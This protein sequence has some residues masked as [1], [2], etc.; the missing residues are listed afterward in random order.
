MNDLDVTLMAI[1]R[2][3]IEKLK[4][5]KKRMGWGFPYVSSNR[6]DFN[7]DFGFAMTEEQMAS[8]EMVG[9]LQNPPAWLQEWSRSV[10]TDRATGMREC[11]GWD[12][13]GI[14]DLDIVRPLD[15]DVAPSPPASQ[16]SGRNHHLGSLPAPD[17]RPRDRVASAGQPDGFLEGPHRMIGHLRA[18][19]AEQFDRHPRL[20]VERAGDPIAVALGPGPVESRPDQVRGDQV[21]HGLAV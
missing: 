15:L 13:L 14:H 1:S 21:D 17:V 12:V 11:P 10:G 2:A 20:V 4:A 19:P 16:L 9:M 6:N 8:P 5:Y 18:I 3:P 7:V